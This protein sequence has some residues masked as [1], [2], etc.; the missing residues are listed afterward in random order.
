MQ[1]KPNKKPTM[2][3]NVSLFLSIYW[4]KF[5]PLTRILGNIIFIIIPNATKYTIPIPDNNVPA[6]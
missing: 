6:I 5:I 4:S 2:V 3:K 1:I